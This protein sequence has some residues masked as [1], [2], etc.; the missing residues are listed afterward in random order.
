MD[1]NDLTPIEEHNGILLK[2][3]DLFMPFKDIPLSGGK[4]RQCLSLFN[5]LKSKIR[6]DFNNTVFAIG[7][8]NS[9]QSIIVTKCAKEFDFNSKIFIPKNIR[10]DN[11]LIQNVLGQGGT[12]NNQAKVGHT[13]VMKSF[14]QKYSVQYK[15]F[16]VNY[17]SNVLES[18]CQNGL[19]MSIANQ[20]Q[21]LPDLEYLI[22]PCGSCIMLSGI[23]IGIRKFRKKI[24][25]VI[26]IQIS[27]HDKVQFI[28]ELS[29][30]DNFKLIVRND[31]PYA[32]QVKAKIGEVLLDPLYEAKAFEYIQTNKPELL[33]KETCFWLSGNSIPV[34]TN[35]FMNVSEVNDFD[36]N[37]FSEIS[38]GEW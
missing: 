29:Q 7:S 2:R 10:S 32:K 8:A 28:K 18:E 16:I 4:V 15:G 1:I 25:N 11:V 19:L 14:I 34:R 35:V 3:D 23:L 13:S 22:V 24:R 38:L 9:P 36:S 21:N 6:T 12:I 27:G 17:T 33:E 37:T 30:T 31:Y 5:D 20:V 26:G